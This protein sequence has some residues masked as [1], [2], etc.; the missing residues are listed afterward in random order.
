MS[1]N[2]PK[3]NTIKKFLT[4]TVIIAI[5]LASVLIVGGLA[6]VVLTNPVNE[7]V[8]GTPTTIPTATPTA[9]PT[10]TPTIQPT[11]I[12][13]SSNNTTPFAKGSTVKMW[14]TVTPAQAGVNVT[15]INNGAPLAWN[16]TNSD[17]IATFERQPQNKYN[18]SISMIP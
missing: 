9:T 12:H 4:P 5:I 6:A 11:E 13:L 14:A 10:V 17:G 8:T 3:T 18:Y 2:L 15:L 16:L 7:N 1:T